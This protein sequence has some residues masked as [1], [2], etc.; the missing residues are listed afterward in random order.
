MFVMGFRFL[1][2]IP[3]D[4]RADRAVSIGNP[5]PCHEFLVIIP[6]FR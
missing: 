2:G 5:E 6:Y 3:E 1:G 4:D